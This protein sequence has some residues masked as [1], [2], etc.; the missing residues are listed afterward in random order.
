M[1]FGELRLK[2]D[3]LKLASLRIE[4]KELHNAIKKAID[5]LEENAFC[6][7]QIPKR[8]IPAVYYEKYNVKNLWKYNLPKAWRLIYTIKHEE[9]EVVSII[10]EWLPHKEYERKFGY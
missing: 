9:I 6:G 1:N 5:M 4:E 7:T 10:L 2:E 8:Q 3:Y